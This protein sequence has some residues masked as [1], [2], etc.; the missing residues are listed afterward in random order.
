MSDRESEYGPFVDSSRIFSGVAPEDLLPLK[1]W[2]P[3][4][5][6]SSPQPIVERSVAG[7]AAGVSPRGFD[8]AFHAGLE[9]IASD[10][11]ALDRHLGSAR[12]DIKLLGSTVDHKL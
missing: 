5:G 1:S 7:D 12:T 3:S 11:L 6:A 10:L 4:Q 8:A 9:L 2:R